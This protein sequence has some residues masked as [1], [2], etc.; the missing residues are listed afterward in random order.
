MASLG[1]S[2]GRSTVTPWALIG[3]SLLGMIAVLFVPQIADDLPHPGRDQQSR[4]ALTCAVVVLLT[5][6]GIYL[7]GR[8][9]S[10][11]HRWMGAA[12]V[13]TVG[14]AVVRFI[15]SPTAFEKSGDTPL[16]DF[17]TTGL[18]VMFLY[19][20]FF[21]LL[22]RAARSRPWGWTWSVKVGIAATIA[23]TAVATRLVV[24]ALLGTGP[25]YLRDL[26]GSGLVLPAVVFVAVR[27]V[28]RSFD[29]AGTRV[30]E[31]LQMYIALVVIDHVLL[32]VYM[33]GLFA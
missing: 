28:I 20:V 32:V 8:D 9:L 1:G 18:F 33:N 14:L 25:A 19:V 5:F 3:L 15:L 22:S 26:W 23:L 21:V 6:A 2:A 10:L 16:A 7:V 13:F 24:S 4:F 11:D 29:F 30:A 17:I 31:T 12:G 27:S